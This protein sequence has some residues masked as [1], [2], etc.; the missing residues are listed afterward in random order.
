[1]PLFDETLVAK[2]LTEMRSRTEAKRRFEEETQEAAGPSTWKPVDPGPYLRGEIE[3]PRPTLGVAR[4]DGA[5]FLYP[6]RDHS[7]ISDTGAGKTWIA[8]AC[9]LAE[10]EA[11]NR[12]VYVHYEEADPAST[13]ERLLLPGAKCR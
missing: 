1:M 11:G 7:V 4:S 12:V 3:I 8:D 6:G 9:A 5:R 13:A 2:H 10:I